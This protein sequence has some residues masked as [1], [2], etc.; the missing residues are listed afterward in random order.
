MPYT[1]PVPRPI[2]AQQFQAMS[3][4]FGHP[5]AAHFREHIR[6]MDCYALWHVR[7][8]QQYN[9]KSYALTLTDE[10]LAFAKRVNEVSRKHN[11][12]V[13]AHHTAH[14]ARINCSVK[15]LSTAMGLPAP[16]VKSL[17][18]PWIPPPSTIH[19]WS[20]SPA[21]IALDAI[22]SQAANDQS[23]ECIWEVVIEYQ[24]YLVKYHKKNW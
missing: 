13:L 3:S 22:K 8:Q 14:A 16:T 1:L 2:V 12:T 5:D 23:D 15:I 4:I 21:S 11:L 19:K 6:K 10:A 9:D 18:N 7:R 17:I 20:A 24:Q